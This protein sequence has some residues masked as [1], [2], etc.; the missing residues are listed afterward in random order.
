M[1][2]SCG[3]IDGILLSLYG[4]RIQEIA[5]QKTENYMLKQR[6]ELYQV[7]KEE[8]TGGMDKKVEEKLN[9]LA[10]A[11]TSELDNE[12][13]LL[14]QQLS[15]GESAVKKL[16]EE[17]KELARLY[18]E[19]HGKFDSFKSDMVKNLDETKQLIKGADSLDHNMGPLQRAWTKD[20][21]AVRSTP[22]LDIE[23]GSVVEKENFRMTAKLIEKP[24][25]LQGQSYRDWQEDVFTWAKKLVPMQKTMEELGEAIIKDSFEGHPTERRIARRAT[26]SPDL[27]AIM[28]ELE[29]EAAPLIE[30]VHR[31]MQRL[32]PKLKRPAGASPIVWLNLMKDIF[33]MEEEVFGEDYRTDETKH[34]LTLSSMFLERVTEQQLR[35]FFDRRAG[36]NFP[37]LKSILQRLNIKDT[38]L[39][40]KKTNKMY[41]RHDDQLD[42]MEEALG[43]FGESSLVRSDATHL[44]ELNKYYKQI[45]AQA[46]LATHAASSGGV[47]TPR[48]DGASAGNMH[49][50]PPRKDLSKAELET[51][52]KTPCRFGM[53]CENLLKK[54]TCL[55]K[56]TASEL[57][58]C[59][60]VWE[61]N[62]PEEAKKRK[63]WVE[64][65]KK[66]QKEKADKEKT[67]QKVGQT[68]EVK[69]DV[70]MGVASVQNSKPAGGKISSFNE[71]YPSQV[72]SE[73]NV[74]N[75]P[76]LL[77]GPFLKDYKV[78]ICHD[79]EPTYATF[80]GERKEL[81]PD[82]PTAMLEIEFVPAAEVE[83]SEIVP[84]MKPVAGK[85]QSERRNRYMIP[86]KK[87]NIYSFLAQQAPQTE[88]KN[89]TTFNKVRSSS[90]SDDKYFDL[91]D[92]ERS[93]VAQSFL[94]LGG[95]YGVEPQNEMRDVLDSAVVFAALGGQ[96]DL[97]GDGG[98]GL[99]SEED[100]QENDENGEEEADP[101]L[102][103]I[104]NMTEEQV[105]AA[106]DNMLATEPDSDVNDVD[107]A[108]K[109]ELNAEHMF[110]INS[111]PVLGTSLTPGGGGGEN[112]RKGVY[113]FTA[114]PEIAK[115]LNGTRRKHG[116]L[117]HLDPLC[118]DF[119]QLLNGRTIEDKLNAKDNRD[120]D[121]V[122]TAYEINTNR[123]FAPS[124][125]SGHSILLR[126]GAD[127]TPEFISEDEKE[128][129]PTAGDFWVARIFYEKT[130]TAH[131][132]MQLCA[133]EGKSGAVII[134]E[135]T[136][137][138][139]GFESYYVPSV[140]KEVAAV[141]NHGV[142]GETKMRHEVTDK[143]IMSS[144]L[145][146]VIKVDLTTGKASRVK[147]R[148]VSRGFED[149][150]FGKKNGNS[151]D[152]RSFT[153]SDASFLM[154]MQFLQATRCKAWFGD[155]AEA[156]LKGMLFD[157][158]Y[159]DDY[160]KDPT[161]QVWMTVP[162]V[163]QDMKE[164]GLKELVRL[165]RALYGCKDAPLC[166]QR[167]FHNELKTLGFQQ[168]LIDPCLWMVFATRR[169]VEV[170]AQ[171]EE[172]VK[173]YFWSKI[174]EIDQTDKHD[175]GKCR[176][177][178]CGQG[179]AD[180]QY[181]TISPDSSSF[182][183]PQSA[184]V[185]NALTTHYRRPGV[186]LGAIGSHVD[187]TVSGGMLLFMLRIYSLFRK[188]PLGSWTK[189]EPGARDCFIGREVQCTPAIFDQKRLSEMLN[190][191][192]DEIEKF[193][194]D[195]IEKYHKE[196]DETE[197][198]RL[199]KKYETPHTLTPTEYKKAEASPFSAQLVDS[200]NCCTEPKEKNLRVDYMAL[201]QLR[202]EGILHIAHIP[203][204][205][206]WTDS[207]TK[208][209]REVVSFLIYLS[210]VWGIADQ[211]VA[212]VI[213]E[214][215]EKQRVKHQQ[216]PE[217]TKDIDFSDD[218]DDGDAVAFLTTAKK[219]SV[220]VKSPP[221]DNKISPSTT[222]KTLHTSATGTR[223]GD[224][225]IIEEGHE[226]GD[227]LAHLLFPSKVPN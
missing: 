222:T 99:L 16:Q 53:K 123:V 19:H 59:K 82:A 106:L 225:T 89:K 40:D 27:G 109:R 151:L 4:N 68:S 193:E 186:I 158:A 128:W 172:E 150:R 24:P 48:D 213:E 224:V 33:V 223:N 90:P 135:K 144:R 189:L 96:V 197:V 73:G 208:S 64:D 178:L 86:K 9:E 117:M 80:N 87:N 138:K 184:A 98:L 121:Y 160:K 67:T 85:K 79:E 25:K 155:V 71:V 214:F 6:I 77:G 62:N 139:M 55:R 75:F 147:S 126:W 192:K 120:I 93:L 201:A 185:T 39:Y 145:V 81:Y 196:V 124:Q 167:S 191:N 1:S 12:L 176:E 97:E 28:L 129:T 42:H 111:T 21:E 177:I 57:A 95:H 49:N 141:V 198:Q 91:G 146:V 140:R 54:G 51:L 37:H 122:V 46:F 119:S 61:K 103:D 190:S 153:M 136:A 173:K 26:G 41:V 94:I 60:G 205:Y 47:T 70:S 58:H 132:K 206:N 101:N 163:I 203:G 156:F 217:E 18:G 169:E 204:K 166:W 180:H 108:L 8:N 165:V 199:E 148:W 65:Q 13:V 31:E 7:G 159:G 174:A 43:V 88:E 210:S 216:M 221:N 76:V 14:R 200:E 134:D 92:T 5:D 157:E 83:I 183:N 188:F 182:Q 22:K 102:I 74:G 66:K 23:S 72:V 10:Q 110:Q 3:C 15:N 20:W 11:K 195:I 149:R 187:D 152:C 69:S 107:M 175:T 215:A 219:H 30:N 34:E 17:K 32:I 130:N 36:N 52:R 133:S 56:H 114:L 142:F 100:E 220:S 38:A 104:D 171:G 194:I 168:S 115:K 112:G 218:E 170:L 63:Q 209:V 164:F 207:L 227:Q 113:D 45:K 127:T 2:T 137:A 211:K 125:Y 131:D 116:R 29:Q 161:S 179:D 162:K 78:N 44:V 154:L 212:K 118:F 181:L 202:E 84:P 50:D 226:A 105:L 143:N 35:S